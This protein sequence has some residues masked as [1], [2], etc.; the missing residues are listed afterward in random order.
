MSNETTASSLWSPRRQNAPSPSSMNTAT[1]RP[2]S[3]SPDVS[4]SSGIESTRTPPRS[5][6]VNSTGRLGGPYRPAYDHDKITRT[7]VP[8]GIV[9]ATA[10]TE[11][12]SRNGWF[13]SCRSNGFPSPWFDANPP[14]SSTYDAAPVFPSGYGTSRWF[15]ATRGDSAGSGRPWSSRIA[16]SESSA[17]GSRT[18]RGRITNEPYTPSPVTRQR[19]STVIVGS[20]ASSGRTASTSSMTNGASSKFALIPPRP[21]GSARSSSAFSRSRWR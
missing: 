17:S 15:R 7:I 10:T 6:T 9:P 2:Y 3:F 12:V 11:N 20:D 16:S 21:V 1:D 19:G 8:E 18:R 13:S 5:V 4:G 14:S